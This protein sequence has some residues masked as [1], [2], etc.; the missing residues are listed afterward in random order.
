MLVAARPGSA[1]PLRGSE[2]RIL[3]KLEDPGSASL[4][5]ASIP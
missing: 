2:T 3:E 1:V 5:R 4:V